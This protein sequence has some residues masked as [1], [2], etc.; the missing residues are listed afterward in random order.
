ME[1]FFISTRFV[2]R[3]S[4][5]VFY[6][7]SLNHLG[8]TNPNYL[9]GCMRNIKSKVDRI[10]LKHK[11]DDPKLHPWQKKRDAMTIRKTK[12]AN[13]YEVFDEDGVC[14]GFLVRGR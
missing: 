9:G 11:F 8:L 7:M 6:T 5:G 4:S 1:V 3:P 14:L 10:S 2:L 12:R 13:Q